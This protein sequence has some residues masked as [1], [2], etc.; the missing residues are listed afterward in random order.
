MIFFHV[1][2]DK[3]LLAAL[4][5]VTLRHEHLNHT[6]KMTI[7]SI[8]GITFEEASNAL[9]YE[10]SRSLRE[11]IKKLGKKELKESKALLKLQALLGRAE[12][13][14]EKRN[15]FIHG[16][17]AK[18]HDGDPGI[19]GDLGELHPLPTIKELESLANEMAE[20]TQELNDARLFGFLQE[21]IDERSGK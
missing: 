17:W 9:R 15:K 10:G 7:K 5:V 13:V 2:I 3:E 4:G 14:T 16:I 12:R 1:P 19:M 18:E 11:R 6:L 8:A 21:A 20:V